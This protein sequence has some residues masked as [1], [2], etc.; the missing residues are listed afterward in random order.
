MKKLFAIL[1]LASAL[2]VL[3]HGPGKV[4]AGEDESATPA[5]AL[6]GNYAD[7]LHG[8]FA[9]CLAPV[10]PFAEESC[11]TKGALVFPQSIVTAGH[12]T[13]GK[14]GSC[15]TGT[16]TV[17][18]FP[19]DLSPPFVTVFQ[20]VGKSLDY[21]RNTGTGDA[22]FT[23]YVGGKCNGAEFDSTGATIIST[24]NTHFVASDNGKRI[25]GVVTVLTDPT[26]GIGDFSLSF[27]ELKQ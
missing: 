19:V 23:T 18:D 10:S 4:V 5:S 26:K 13:N 9:L 1:F 11:S 27:V 6:R 7:A 2:V 8:S 25:E 3:S 21:D 22:S 20:T 15:E 16:E 12:V 24:G 14:N 17:S